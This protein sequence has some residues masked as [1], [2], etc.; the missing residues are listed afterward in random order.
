MNAAE[1]QTVSLNNEHAKKSEI[2]RENLQQTIENLLIREKQ[3][4]NEGDAVATG[5]IL[6]E[7][8][9]LCFE[10][11]DFKAL[12]ENLVLLSKRRG[13]LKQAIKM[14]VKRAMEFLD[15]LDYDNKIQLINTLRTITE[16]KIFVE[17]QRARLTLLLARIRESEGKLAEAANILQEVPVETFSTM[18]PKEKTNFILEQMRLCLLKR[19]Y[20]RAQIMSRKI[21][22][23]ALEG[24]EYQDEK[25]RYYT[26]M[27]DYYTNEGKFLD[28]ARCWQHIYNTD[29]T[30]NDPEKWKNALKHVILFVILSPY[31]NE[32]S[33]FIN[34]LKENPQL[35]DIPLYKDLV[36]KFL[37]PEIMRWPDV[38]AKFQ[39]DL[40]TLD[41]FQS[42]ASATLWQNFQNRVVEHN[43]RVVAKYYSR[44]TLKRLAEI[45]ALT[46]KETETHLSE[47]VVNKAV[48]ARIDRP[49][50]VIN[51]VKPKDPTQVLSDWSSDVSS[52][53]S[54]I[55]KIS[56]LIQRENMIYKI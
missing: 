42:P 50:G 38:V 39:A 37:T 56:H 21:S 22:S 30:K 43:I 40:N 4:R 24:K 10:R 5:K 45:L 16:G 49:A 15:K 3:A 11:K 52:C 12:N 34:R 19:D 23:K 33:D 9:D 20:V 28:I 1:N 13:Q 41:V 32:Q 47:L 8:I 14:M 53:L 36:K 51:F 25:V 55:D 17:K 54:L 26:L 7:I 35:Q 48:W 18:K 6:V 31:D 2:Q 44:V 27:I 46:E 29:L